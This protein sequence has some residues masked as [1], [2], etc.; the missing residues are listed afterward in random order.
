MNDIVPVQ[1]AG[2]HIHV[3]LLAETSDGQGI[4]FMRIRFVSLSNAES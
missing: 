2:K 1:F 3:L 4:F